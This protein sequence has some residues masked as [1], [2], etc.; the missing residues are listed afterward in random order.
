MW[1][2]NMPWLDWDEEKQKVKEGL[3][4]PAGTWEGRMGSDLGR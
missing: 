1:A 4:I 3:R 2:E